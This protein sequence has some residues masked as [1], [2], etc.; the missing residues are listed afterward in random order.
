MK[1]LISTIL[2]SAIVLSFM[3][4]GGLSLAAEDG[5][6]SLYEINDSDGYFIYT[7]IS[8]EV[9][10]LYYEGTD[11]KIVIPDEID[12]YQVTTIGEYAFSGKE[13]LCILEMP[14]TITSIGE[15]AFG[16]CASLSSV[17]LSNNILKIPD[18]A[19]TSCS[20]LLYVNIPEGITH[21]GFGA[22]ADCGLNGV[23]F[24][25]SLMTIDALAFADNYSLSS[26]SLPENI[27]SI[28]NGALGSYVFDSDEEYIYF[29]Y[30]EFT[31]NGRN[32]ISRNYANLSS[33]FTYYDVSN[34]ACSHNYS[35]TAYSKASTC[36]SDGVD[37][38]SCY[39][40]G[41]LNENTIPKLSSH[42]SYIT[43]STCVTKGYC[44]LCEITLNNYGEHKYTKISEE[45]PTCIDSVDA[46]YQCDICGDI[47]TEEL[48]AT[49]Q[50]SGGTSTCVKGAICETCGVEYGELIDHNYE[51]SSSVEATCTNSAYD[52]YE[53]TMCQDTYY[54][55]TAPSLGGHIGG[56]ATCTQRAECERCLES[57]G[58][59][60]PHEYD[61]SGICQ[62]CTFEKIDIVF[63]DMN[64]DGDI[65]D[66][67]N[68]LLDRYLAGWD[69]DFHEDAADV[70]GDETVDDLDNLLF[71]RYL[72][73][74]E[75]EG[76]IIGKLNKQ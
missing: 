64:N 71:S 55:I 61:D 22:F 57:Y 50:H 8:N 17:K 27:I 46:E 3:S 53:C 45:E 29:D 68:M 25:K 43:P 70:N 24:P 4:F 58:K 20:S 23:A 41:Y 56:E 66:V 13:S 19:F 9:S 37:I 47:K 62:A 49:G 54:V 67:D 48:A 39:V 11:T 15:G 28:G 6:Y 32:Q 30:L 18:Y 59:Y 5:E 73:N 60:L 51:K 42:E 34:Y 75:P 65:D 10:I 52:N 26:V 12:G 74:W 2:L 38:N 40:C 33:R 14:N 76:I 44:S 1:K 72:A 35:F 63:G 31:I 69:I 21:I 16:G 7:I 36:Q